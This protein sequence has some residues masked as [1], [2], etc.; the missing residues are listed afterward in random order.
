[1]STI[2]NALALPLQRNVNLVQLAAGS[3]VAATGALL[4]LGQ[5]FA[6]F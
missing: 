4:A 1:M 5:L 6:H 2:G 3:T